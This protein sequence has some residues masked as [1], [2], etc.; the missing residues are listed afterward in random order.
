MLFRSLLDEAPGVLVLPVEA[1]VA[2]G[3][4]RIDINHAWAGALRMPGRIVA[5]LGDLPAD[6]NP[7]AALLRLAGRFMPH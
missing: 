1:G 4:E 6:W 5:G 3:F 7:V 2:A